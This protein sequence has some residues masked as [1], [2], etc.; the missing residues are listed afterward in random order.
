MADIHI[1]LLTTATGRHVILVQA[2]RIRVT[3]LTGPGRLRPIMRNIVHLFALVRRRR[4]HIC[5]R[6]TRLPVDFLC[7]LDRLGVQSW[8]E[9]RLWFLSAL[10][11]HFLISIFGALE[12]SIFHGQFRFTVA[13]DHRCVAEG[14]PFSLNG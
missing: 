1:F 14:V 7:L 6:I 12:E 4:V 5:L 13:L 3:D 11:C 10:R 2:N 8:F 9:S